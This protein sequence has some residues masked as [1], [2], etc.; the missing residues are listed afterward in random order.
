MSI[1]R[2]LP[3]SMKCACAFGAVCL[4]CALLGIASLTGVLKVNA[5]VNDMVDRSMSSM[6]H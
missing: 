3:F 2:N 4:V 6:S 1:L 5:A